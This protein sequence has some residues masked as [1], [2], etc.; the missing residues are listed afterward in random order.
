MVFDSAG[1]GVVFLLARV[2]FGGVMA[3]TGLNHFLDAEGMIGYAQ[4]KGIPAASLGVPFSGGMLIAG[5]LGLILG[6]Y[7][8]IAAGAIAVFLVGA[9]PTMHDFWNAPEDQR[10][11]EFNNFLKNVALLGGALVFLAL[12]SSAWPLA[13]NV[14][15]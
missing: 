2:L 15:L 8:T 10:Q 14:G 5:G 3:F 1:A 13:A 12:A 9:T 4:A 11:G 7:P 6:V